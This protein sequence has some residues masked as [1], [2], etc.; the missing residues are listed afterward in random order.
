MTPDSQQDNYYN[1]IIL[2]YNRK[3]NSKILAKI[4]ECLHFFRQQQKPYETRDGCSFHNSEKKVA[5]A[6]I[7]LNQNNECLKIRQAEICNNS[8][9]CLVLMT[10]KTSSAYTFHFNHYEEVRYILI[11]IHHVVLFSPLV[12]CQKTKIKYGSNYKPRILIPD[13]AIN[14]LILSGF[15]VS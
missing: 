5:I 15:L 6:L 2:T 7:S 8:S 1:I 13:K 3:Q 11:L 14:R 9:G 12:L 4:P 10:S